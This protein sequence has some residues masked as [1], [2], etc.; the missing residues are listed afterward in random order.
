[1]ECGE[2]HDRDHREDGNGDRERDAALV[3]PDVGVRLG[4]AQPQDRAD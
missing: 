2:E 1:V 3:A 4:C